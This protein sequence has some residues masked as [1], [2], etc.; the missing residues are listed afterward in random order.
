MKL[1][2]IAALVIGSL[3]ANAQTKFCYINHR[4]IVPV[5]VN[6]QGPFNFLLDTGTQITIVDPA[7]I[8]LMHLSRPV[9][10]AFVGG[11]GVKDAA[12]GGYTTV[13]S[14]ELDS[15]KLLRANVVL[16]DVARSQQGQSVKVVGILGQNFLEYFDVLIRYKD[17]TVKLNP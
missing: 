8:G 10:K 5:M 1:C 11:I 9:G 2:I 7:M 3:A 17:S 15:H 4:V 13:D 12:V 16:F 14:I 6:G